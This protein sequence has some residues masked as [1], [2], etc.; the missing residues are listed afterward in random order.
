MD[1]VEDLR[2]KLTNIHV[3]VSLGRGVRQRLNAT[4]AIQLSPQM[5]RLLV[6]IDKAERERVTTTAA[7]AE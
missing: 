6:A 7:K 4:G 2:R 1:Q 5:C 3:I